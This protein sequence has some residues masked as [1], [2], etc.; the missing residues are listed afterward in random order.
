MSK[1]IWKSIKDTD[2]KYKVSSFGNVYSE[3]SQRILKRSLTKRGYPHVG[4]KRN[5]EIYTR[6]VHR[7]VAETFLGIP[8]GLKNP[9]VNHLDG[10]KTNNRLENLEWCSLSDNA[11]HAYKLGLKDNHRPLLN[12]RTP[13]YGIHKVTGE[14]VDCCTLEDAKSKVGVSIISIYSA[15]TGISHSSAG[16]K[17]YYVD[18]NHVKKKYKPRLK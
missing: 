16:Y 15:L 14:R 4:I 8:T 1:E 18:K 7:L 12:R 9:T 10:I 6:V 11:K 3:H 13:F 2:G 5:G 17:W